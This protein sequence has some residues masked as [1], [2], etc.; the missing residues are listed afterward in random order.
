MPINIRARTLWEALQEP[1]RIT[2]AMTTAYIAMVVVG[3]TSW[4]DPSDYIS[5]AWGG[6][7]AVAWPAIVLVGAALGICATPFGWWGMERA[8]LWICL[9]ATLARIVSLAVL[10]RAGVPG[11]QIIQIGFDWM[12]MV[13]FITRLYRIRGADLDPTR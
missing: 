9:G 10:H 5:T 2:A 7:F 13:L 11:N 4:R 6:P 3:I 1:R 12:V 8:A